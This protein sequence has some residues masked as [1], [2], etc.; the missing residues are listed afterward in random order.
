[1]TIKE[2]LKEIADSKITT[3]RWVHVRNTKGIGRGMSLSDLRD[4]VKLWSDDI[5]ESE[6]IDYRERVID[7]EKGIFLQY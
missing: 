4:G 7:C 3:D 5:L 2:K 6:L 1:M